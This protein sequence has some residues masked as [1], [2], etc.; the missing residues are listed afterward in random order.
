M[1]TLVY[2][3]FRVSAVVRGVLVFRKKLAGF[4]RARSRL[5]IT[6]LFPYHRGYKKMKG[7]R[8]EYGSAD[9][10][11]PEDDDPFQVVQKTVTSI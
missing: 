11:A 6:L 9:S 7:E 3:E 1:V 4:R 2:N 8:E 10:D 5:Q